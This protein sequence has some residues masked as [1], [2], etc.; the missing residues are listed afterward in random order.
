LKTVNHH[1]FVAITQQVIRSDPVIVSI[2]PSGHCPP[3]YE[4]VVGSQSGLKSASGENQKIFR[5]KPGE[6]VR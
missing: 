2:H 5:Q 4:S 3:I 1:K 6:C